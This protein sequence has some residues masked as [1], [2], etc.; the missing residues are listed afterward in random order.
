VNPPRSRTPCAPA[1]PGQA[2][3]STRISRSRPVQRCRGSVRTMENTASSN[4][5]LRHE[6]ALGHSQES[7]TGDDTGG[8]P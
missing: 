2:P 7:G 3:D 5:S 4:H 6:S 1:S 8:E